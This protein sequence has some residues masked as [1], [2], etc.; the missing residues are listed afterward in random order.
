MK[1]KL[2]IELDI[3]QH[4]PRHSLRTYE[5]EI[6]ELL[7]LPETDHD[8]WV[9]DRVTAHDSLEAL[10]AARALHAVLEGETPVGLRP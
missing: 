6:Y 1:R 7:K 5:G 8:P 3:T 9:C 4:N 10:L 2:F